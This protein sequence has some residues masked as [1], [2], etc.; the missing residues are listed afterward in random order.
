MADPT[1]TIGQLVEQYQAGVLARDAEAMVRLVESYGRV[2][3][4]IA[5]QAD[6]LIA[7]VEKLIA[8]GQKRSE[9]R[10]VGKECRL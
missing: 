1:L 3:T 8:Q 6:A 7:E 2:Y 10:R 5:A 9:E 4:Q